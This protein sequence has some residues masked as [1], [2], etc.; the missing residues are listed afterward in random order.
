MDSTFTSDGVGDGSECS[1]T[2]QL[3][4]V[5]VLERTVAKMEEVIADSH[6]KDRRISSL[7][8]QLQAVLAALAK[9]PSTLVVELVAAATAACQSA[10]GSDHSCPSALTFVSAVDRSQ[11]LTLRSFVRPQISLLSISLPHFRIV[12]AN[13]AHRRLTGWADEF[14]VGKLMAWSLSKDERRRSDVAAIVKKVQARQNGDVWVQKVQ[15]YCASGVALR[16]LLR[17]NKEKI[18]VV[19]RMYKSDGRL[20]ETE[21]SFWLGRAV[22]VEAADDWQ[23]DEDAN[24]NNRIRNEYDDLSGIQAAEK[25][26]AGRYLIVAAAWQDAIEIT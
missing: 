19:W 18:D 10:D 7:Q 4:K 24:A 12:D 16:E 26:L 11:C 1:H 13:S 22:A 15:Q 17:G 8:C 20:Y 23:E 21:C 6:N 9:K 5:D 3:A 25:R 2:E 14:I